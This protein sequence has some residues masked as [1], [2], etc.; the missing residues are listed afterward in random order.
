MQVVS[1]R[2][3]DSALRMTGYQFSYAMYA[4]LFD[5]PILLPLRRQRLS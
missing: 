4:S 1:R 2:T 3:M 5:T